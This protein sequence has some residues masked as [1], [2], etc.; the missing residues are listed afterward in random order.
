M[1]LENNPYEINMGWTVDLGQ[2]ADCI[3]KQALA[4]ISNDGVTQR[5]LGAVPEGEKMTTFNEHHWPAFVDGAP[6]GYLT[7]CV[8]SPR[9]EQNLAFVMAKNE[10]ANAGQNI[11]IRSQEGSINATLCELPFIKKRQ[12]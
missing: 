2:S 10:Y 3:G 1:R 6:A 11:E 9:L 8:Y 4:Q 7:T 5:L 12:E